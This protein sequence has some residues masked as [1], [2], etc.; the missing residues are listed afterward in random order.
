MT[1]AK[2]VSAAGTEAGISGRHFPHRWR[3]PYVTSLL[4]RGS[5]IH[6]VQRLL[7]Q[8]NIDT[9]TRYL[10]LSDADLPTQ[11]TRRPPPRALSPSRISG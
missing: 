7:G 4:H 2:A 10:H 11:R 9:T 8:A 6:V 1:V 5:V 3:Q